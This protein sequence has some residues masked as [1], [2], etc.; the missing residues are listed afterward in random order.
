MWVTQHDGAGTILEL[1]P[2]GATLGTFT[3]GSFS[4]GIAFDGAHMWVANENDNDVT[5]L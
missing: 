2:T 4:Q 1:S 3:L 5:E